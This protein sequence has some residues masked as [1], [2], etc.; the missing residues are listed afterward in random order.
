[1][2][3][4]KKEGDM[5]IPQ[6]APDDELGKQIQTWE[7]KICELNAKKSEI[8][9]RGAQETSKLQSELSALEEEVKKNKGRQVS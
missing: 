3:L 6:S 4:L 9:E 5:T 7:D 1:M 2:R 8:L